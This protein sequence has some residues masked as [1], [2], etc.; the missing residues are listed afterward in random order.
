MAVAQSF[1][2]CK[3]AIEKIISIA[4]IYKIDKPYMVG[5][6]VR[7]F[8]L[9]IRSNLDDID[10]TTNSSECIRLGILLS[11][12]SNNMFRMFDDRHIRVFFFGKNID[13]SPGV[14][15]FTHSGV[16]DWVRK[17][18][19]NNIRFVE[20]FSRDFTINSMHQ[21]FETG[22]VIDPTG[23]GL[24]D[25]DSKVIRCSI[26]AAIAIKNDPRRVFRAIRFASKFGFSI[27]G[28]IVNFVN[29]NPDIFLDTKLTQQ[30]IS[31]EINEALRYDGDRA[32]SNIFELDLLKRIPLSGM[33]SDFLIKNKL[34]SKYLS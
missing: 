8:V 15:S 11:R 23:L 12:G 3:D 19:P 27:D 6:R 16:F 14:L 30:Y 33:Y 29:E 20:S 17:N 2:D 32:I 31:M 26:P 28:D 13:F 9:N 18:N 25:I 10:I 22:E 5:G 1:I 24:I 34:L 7:D 4:T 21:D